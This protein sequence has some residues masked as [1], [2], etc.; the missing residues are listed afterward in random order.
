MPLSF[1]YLFKSLYDT[2]LLDQL[3]GKMAYTLIELHSNKTKTANSINYCL[4]AMSIVLLCG[5]YMFC[6]YLYIYS[7]GTKTV[8]P[9]RIISDK[10]LK[11]PEKNTF[12]EWTSKGMIKRASLLIFIII[13]F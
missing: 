10:E 6:F 12:E 11:Q 8:R 1:R 3:N 5:M 4:K 13:L 2:S 7:G 9:K